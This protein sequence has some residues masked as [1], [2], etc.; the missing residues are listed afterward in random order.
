MIKTTIQHKRLVGSHL[1]FDPSFYFRH[2]DIQKLLIDEDTR[3]V[4]LADLVD[5]VRGEARVQ[6]SGDSI[7]LVRLS[8]L[9]LCELNPR[10]LQSIDAD[11]SQSFTRAYPGDVL[12][13]RS[14]V[15]FRAAVVPANTP[16]PLVVSSEITV[17]RLRGA[18]VPE[19]LAA[20]LSTGAYGKVLQDLS[21]RRS[22]TAVPRLR[23]HDIYHL[24]IPLP[25]RQLQE[26]I[27]TAYNLAT[28]L[29]QES[30]EDISSIVRS[31]HAEIDAKIS[32]VQ[33]F[34]DVFNVQRAK[35]GNRWDVS[36][37]KGRILHNILAQTRVMVPLL[38]LAHPVPSSLRG[39]AE[40]DLVLV[41]KA[42]DINEYSFMVERPQSIMLKDLSPR[43][44]QPLSVGDV[45]I[46]T[47]GQ[48]EQVAFLDDTLASMGLPLLGSATFTALR[49]SETP[50]F[51]AVAL[52]HPIV[53]NQI[54]LLSSGTV[55]RFV[56]KKDLDE[57][58]VPNLGQIWREDFELRIERAIERR[59][60]AL[61]ALDNLLETA[62][63]FAQEGWQS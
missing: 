43:M 34:H 63:R 22:P 36:Y 32:H 19:Y 20:L 57:L 10:R 38:S 23:L 33:P 35:L 1:R 41:I 4:E 52:T 61:A 24:P 28:R 29:S 50:R 21:Y 26:E 6:S 46:C 62:Q 9:H 8:D 12:F 51:Y 47:T 25:G 5:E 45:L 2:T 40:D 27:R 56:N 48:G 58:L 37:A 13:A 54:Q 55:Q 53:R 11:S 42:D 31:V 49:F 39:I 60:E 15:P 30:Q 7:P 3:L 44:R 14:T 18:V 59:R 16:T 17:I